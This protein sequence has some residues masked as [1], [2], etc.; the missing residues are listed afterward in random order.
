MPRLTRQS[1]RYPRRTSSSSPRYKSKQD[2]PSAGRDDVAPRSPSEP[3]AH[4]LSKSDGKVAHTCATPLC[5]QAMLYGAARDDPAVRQSCR[6]PLRQY[7]QLDTAAMV[8]VWD[9]WRQG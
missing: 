4:T 8:M 5:Y 2:A 1:E 6:D 9:H 3:V 7:C